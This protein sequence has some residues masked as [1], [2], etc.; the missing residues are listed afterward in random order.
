M[1]N[2]N[3]NA[4]GVFLRTLRAKHNEY[5]KDMAK[6][7]NVSPQYLSKLE[8]GSRTMTDTVEA[9]LIREYNLRGEDVKALRKARAE[10]NEE[11]KF[12]SNNSLPTNKV[13]MLKELQGA[14]GTMADDDVRTVLRVLNK[15]KPRGVA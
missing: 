12:N 1:K 5:Q 4:V 11:V 10:S 2:K 3:T 7:L 14:I 8:L 13:E 9:S 15:H 6:R